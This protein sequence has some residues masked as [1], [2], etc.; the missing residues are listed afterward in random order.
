MAAKSKKETSG[1]KRG[2]VK[3]SNIEKTG[4][5]LDAKELKKVRGGAIG[6]ENPKL[7]KSVKGSMVNIN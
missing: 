7:E 5:K 2:R 3:V 4:K 6:Q 1:K